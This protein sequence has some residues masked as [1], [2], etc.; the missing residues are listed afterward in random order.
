M[1]EGELSHFSTFSC[2]LLRI[3]RSSLKSK[4]LWHISI[5]V[6]VSIFLPLRCESCLAGVPSQSRISF[7][8]SYGSDVTC[9]PQAPVFEHLFPKCHCFGRLRNPW[10][11][12]PSCRCGSW[13]VDPSV[14]SLSPK[15]YKQ[16]A[17]VSA[18]AA[19]GGSHRYTVPAM[20]DGL[21]QPWSSKSSPSLA[22]LP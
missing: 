6:D 11:V 22:G 18:A 16:A 15:R 21:F 20:A 17:H 4:E 3:P 2:P 10:E 9:P 5:N 12:G 13:G 14:C 7:D 1:S 8:P 19:L